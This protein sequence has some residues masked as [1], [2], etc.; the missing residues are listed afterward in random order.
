MRV[1]L[2]ATAYPPS[3]GGAQLLMHQLAR[4]LAARHEVR[5]VSQWDT[6]R[7]DWLLGTTLRAPRDPHSYR[8]DGVPVERIALPARVRRRL[9]PW[10]LLYYPLQAPALVRIARALAD[11]IA[12]S[13]DGIDLIHNCRIGREGLSYA[14][15]LVA[16]AREVPFVLT[17]VHHPRWGGWL[18]RHYLRL[19]RQADALIVL[20]DAERDTLL[21]LGVAETRVFV[22]GMG[23]ILDGEGEGLRFRTRYGLGPA[24][25][26]L[27]V[28]QQ[29]AYKGIAKL[30]E[31]AREV[32]QH[33]PDVRFV[34]VGPHT[35]Y[36]RR[37]FASVR[38]PRVHNLGPVDLRE[39][40]DALAASDILCLPSVQESFGAVF[41]EAWS[42]GK[43]VVGC[44]IPAVR[45]VVTDG[46]DGFLA[47]ADAGAIAERL[48]Y[49]LDRPT[50]RK[51][52]G[53][54]GRA[55]VAERYTWTRL[56]AVTEA[57]YRTVLA[58]R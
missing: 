26:V 16:R 37:L 20:T 4:E 48:S 11:Q 5:V 38:D 54:R 9:V 3:I 7:T 8:I 58:N 44:D 49:L 28:G 30:L 40:T 34:F 27:F 39:K 55:K 22:T 2:T 42:L 46:K 29:Y 13:A 50:L 31:A 10:V 51:E 18:H 57:V 23:P 24:P 12:P 1:L 53:A 15:L 25:I 14:S 36:S 41:T 21:D 33:A 43:P 17:P 56:A 45:S 47:P 6:L 32:W 52:M 35:R 19:Y